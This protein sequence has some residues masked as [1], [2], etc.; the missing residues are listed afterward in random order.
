MQ[1]GYLATLKLELINT[2][3]VIESKRIAT[4]V[5]NELFEYVH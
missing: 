1:L 2:L 5:E 3:S 4:N